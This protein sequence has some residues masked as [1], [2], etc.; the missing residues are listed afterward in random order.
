MP[1]FS[2]LSPLVRTR[3][4]RNVVL[5][6]DVT[7][8]AKDGKVYRIGLGST[9]DGASTPNLLWVTIPPFGWYWLAAVFHDWL[10]RFSDVPDEE[11]CDALLMEAMEILPGYNEF[12][13]R[14]IYEGVHYGGKSSFQ[15]DRAVRALT[16]E[17]VQP[18]P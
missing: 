14:L 13:A 8:T 17:H 18:T 7:Y 6:E 3:D 16:T 2:T 4:G 12:E 11:S 5:A 10:Y 9:S 1:G 15:S